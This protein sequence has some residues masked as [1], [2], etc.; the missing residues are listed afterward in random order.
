MTGKSIGIQIKTGKSYFKSTNATGWNFTGEIKHLNYYLNLDIPVII[1]IVNLNDSKVYWTKFDIN[2]ITKNEKSWTIRIKNSFELN[3]LTLLKSITTKFVDYTPQIEN[4]AKINS[5][6]LNSNTVFIAVDKE[7]IENENYSGIEKLS[8]WL[9]S[10]DKMIKENKGK[11]LI[12]VY[13]Y[14]KDPRELCEIEKVRSWMKVAVP[15]FKYWGYFLHMDE[16][17]KKYSGLGVIRNCCVELY[18]V[19]KINSGT[20]ARVE[21]NLAESDLFVNHIIQWLNEFAD[22]YKIEEHIV[23]EQSMK[24]YQ[25]LSG[26][27]KEEIEELRIKYDF[28]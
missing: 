24:I 16:P 15:K 22:E 25:I 9:T 28:K 13:G 2:E 4:L 5:A 20:D 27:T 23:F 17:L 11:F 18:N 8:K 21:Y 3:N 19:K 14:D 12:A 10:S 26:Y 6:I 7:E 1:A